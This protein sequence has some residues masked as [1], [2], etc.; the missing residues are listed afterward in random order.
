MSRHLDIE[1][2]DQ[3]IIETVALLRDNGVETFESCEGGE[4]H[5]FEH[6]TVRFHGGQAEGFRALSIVMQHGLRPMSLR[7]YWS[8]DGGEP[9]GPHWEIVFRPRRTP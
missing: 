8:M 4:G 2:I 5:H 6:P 1:G 9:T 7:R 3:G